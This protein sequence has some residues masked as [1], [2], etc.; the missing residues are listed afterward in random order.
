M[1]G[2]SEAEHERMK[3][4][5][6]SS[7]GPSCISLIRRSVCQIE[8]T[9]VTQLQCLSPTFAQKVSAEKAPSEG[10]TSDPPE[11]SVER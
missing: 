4:S 11:A 2:A 7:S 6:G 1:V 3:R 8:G 9:A 5:G 10:S